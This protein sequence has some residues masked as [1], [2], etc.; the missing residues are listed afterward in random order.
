MNPQMPLLTIVIPTVNRVELLKCALASAL[1]QTVAVALIV[2]DNGS[3][4]GTDAYLRSL[5][6]PHYVR[7][8]RHEHTMPVQSHATFLISK[9]QTEWVV[10]LSDDDYLEPEFAAE[11]TR[12]IEE[13]P[14]VAFV[15]TGC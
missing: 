1:A 10:F 6:L 7:H 15:Y 5:E 4:D 9:I 8:F 13:K 11:V 3:R 2:S 12:L 14:D